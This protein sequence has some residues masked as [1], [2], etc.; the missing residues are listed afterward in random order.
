[1]VS[2][3][4]SGDGESLVD[5]D[6]HDAVARGEPGASSASRTR[7]ASALVEPEPAN[8][9]TAAAAAEAAVAADAAAVAADTAAEAAEE[10]EELEGVVAPDWARLAMEV[11]E[12][13]E[14]KVMVEAR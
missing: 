4:C 11:L 10:P 9:A 2:G 3:A 12:V 6:D 7:F 1:M 14:D 8:A 5:P 13:R